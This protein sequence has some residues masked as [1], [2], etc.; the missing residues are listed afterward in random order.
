MKRRQNVGANLVENTRAEADLVKDFHD[1]GRSATEPGP[2]VQF[3]NDDWLRLRRELGQDV[4]QEYAN[5]W[6]DMAGVE[7]SPFMM[8]AVNV[9]ADKVNQIPCITHVDGTCRVQTVNEEQ[10]L[11]FYTTL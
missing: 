6:F 2:L 10:N 5:D 9:A 1:L 8:L 3:L 4:L 7:E 11:H